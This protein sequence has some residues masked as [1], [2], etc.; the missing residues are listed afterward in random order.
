MFYNTLDITLDLKLLTF[1]TMHL[2]KIFRGENC[3]IYNKGK[4]KFQTLLSQNQ[5]MLFAH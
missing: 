4:I 2:I 3:M 5:F 1:K